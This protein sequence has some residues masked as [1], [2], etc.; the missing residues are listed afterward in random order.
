MA[1]VLFA[2][3]ALTG[4]VSGCLDDILHTALEDGNTA[5]VI[6][7]SDNTTYFFTYDASEA[8]AES[9]P[10]I[11]IPDSNVS[12][13]GAWVLANVSSANLTVV[14]NEREVNVNHTDGYPGISSTSI[15]LT[16]ST[17]A[18]ATWKSIGPTGGGADH[19]WTALDSLATDIDWIRVRIN[20]VQSP[21]ANGSVSTSYIYA[22]RGGSVITVGTWSQVHASIAVAYGTDARVIELTLPVSARIF[23]LYFANTNVDSSSTYITL[24][25]YGWNP[26]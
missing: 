6:N 8:G 23:E 17:F 15:G 2:A 1:K 3:N 19:T 18:S 7:S 14:E 21:V 16:S 12:G 4:G 11:I 25:G 10:N 5:I 26:A 13:T 9:S 20:Y 22:R 24:V